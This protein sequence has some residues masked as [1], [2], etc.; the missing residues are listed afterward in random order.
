[1]PTIAIVAGMKVLVYYNDH[2]PPHFHVDY[3]EYKAQISMR[4]G[5][6]L[7]GGL[8]SKKLGIIEDWAHKHKEELLECWQ[9]A[10]MNEPLGKIK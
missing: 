2:L 9:K 3:A 4:E 5:K 7:E 8:P 6:L 10:Q 1:M